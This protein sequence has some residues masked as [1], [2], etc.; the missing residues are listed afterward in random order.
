MDIIRVT[1]VSSKLKAP[2]PPPAPQ[3]KDYSYHL[4]QLLVKF[5]SSWMI[6]PIEIPQSLLAPFHSDSPTQSP[7]GD[8]IGRKV[9]KGRSTPRIVQTTFASWPSQVGAVP[10]HEQHHLSWRERER[11]REREN[12]GFCN[13]QPLLF[14][15]VCLQTIRGTGRLVA[16]RTRSP[17]C[18]YR[19]GNE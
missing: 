6:P 3:P 19:A 9:S 15:K 8:G 5:E 13:P 4:T 17:R 1:V 11:E 2:P 10:Y 7:A 12:D 18:I 14:R 16:V